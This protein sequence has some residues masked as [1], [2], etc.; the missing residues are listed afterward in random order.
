MKSDSAQVA[1]QC[2]ELIEQRQGEMLRQLQTVVET[3]SPSSNKAA[4]DVLGGHLLRE[5]ER[6]GGKVTIHPA[7]SYGDHLQVDFDGGTSV[8]AK[9]GTTRTSSE[10]PV[11][12][13][14]H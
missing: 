8:G 12:L 1:K 5:F 14:G 11:L 6:I 2:L 10:K 7:V 13:L 4:V 3:E 9:P